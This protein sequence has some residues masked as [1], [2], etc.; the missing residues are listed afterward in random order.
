[1]LYTITNTWA[2]KAQ[3]PQEIPQQAP[4]P[5]VRIRPRS[6]SS[7]PADA[8]PEAAPRVARPRTQTTTPTDAPPDAAPL[9]PRPARPR[10]VNPPAPSGT[11]APKSQTNTGTVSTRPHPAAPTATVS[12]PT[13]KLPRTDPSTAKPSSN[14]NAQSTTTSAAPARLSPVLNRT[15][16]VLDPAHGGGDSGSRIGDNTLEKDVTLALAFRLR[17]LLTAR[18]F[19]VVLTRDSD[20]VNQGNAPNNPSPVLSLDSRAGTAN[21]FRAAACV[22][23]HATGRGTGVHLY[24]SELQP[25]PFEVPLLPWLTGQAAWIPASRQLA[26][27]LGTALSRSQFPLVTSSA[28]I[29]PVDSLT[30]PAVVLELAPETADARSINDAGYQE[31]VASALAGALVFWQNQVQP[32]PRL[33]PPPPATHPHRQAPRP[34]PATQDLQP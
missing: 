16:I 23:L 7:V 15:Y 27:T 28:S 2:V 12:T 22:L 13:T 17:S 9:A 19:T 4:A 10:P 8:P 26:Q 14:D 31:R 5:I 18:G 6:Q 24:T 1:M 32:P 21:H 3:T 33:T 34:M 29:R 25:T 30:C 20:A 11:V